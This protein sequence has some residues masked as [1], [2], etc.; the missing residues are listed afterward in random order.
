MRSRP[1]TQLPQPAAAAGRRP[2][3]RQ[4][5]RA[6]KVSSSEYPILSKMGRNAEQ[7]R[8]PT[9]GWCFHTGLATSRT[10]VSTPATSRS[11]ATIT[12]TTRA[13]E[14]APCAG[15]NS[16]PRWIDC[17]K[18]ACF[19]QPLKCAAASSTATT[20]PAPTG[21]SPAGRA[22]PVP[23]ARPINSDLTTP[24]SAENATSASAQTIARHITTTT[25][26]FDATRPCL[27]A[28]PVKG[29]EYYS[30][31]PRSARSASAKG[32]R[33]VPALGTTAA[34]MTAI[35][36]TQ[37]AQTAWSSGTKST[38]AS[39]NPPA[40]SVPAT[41]SQSFE[42]NTPTT[43]PHRGWARNQRRALRRSCANRQP[44]VNAVGCLFAP[45]V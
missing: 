5:A 38:P 15:V 23:F 8:Y 27:R 41:T 6:L 42:R 44:A 24:S 32:V 31:S 21:I 22:T 1:S 17:S 39:D 12:P 2:G 26:A 35:C 43:Y 34:R 18:R 45:F 9:V 10:P 4:A 37:S 19:R 28:R 29:E 20:A 30:T 7:S 40:T 25:S 16:T 13:T 33:L 14:T 36:V 11:S 3:L